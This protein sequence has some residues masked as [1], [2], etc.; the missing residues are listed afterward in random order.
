MEAFAQ[1]YK[2]QIMPLHVA[3]HYLIPEKQAASLSENF[4]I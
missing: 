1:R 4:D 3:A 2:R